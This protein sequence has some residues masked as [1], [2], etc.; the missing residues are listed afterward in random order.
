MPKYTY[1]AEIIGF[2]VTVGAL[3]TNLSLPNVETRDR[4]KIAGGMV[5]SFPA[6]RKFRKNSVDNISGL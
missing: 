4:W 5:K 2:F 3:G 1:F 6:G